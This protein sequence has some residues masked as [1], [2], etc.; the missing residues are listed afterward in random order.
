MHEFDSALG[1]RTPNLDFS[2]TFINDMI[3]FNLNSSSANNNSE[4]AN[5][6]KIMLLEY[7]PHFLKLSNIAELIL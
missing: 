7:E 4:W 3:E 1:K 6:N 5:V 2:N